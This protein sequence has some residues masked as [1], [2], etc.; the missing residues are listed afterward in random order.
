MTLKHWKNKVHRKRAYF[1]YTLKTKALARDSAFVLIALTGIATEDAVAA[2]LVLE[3]LNARDTLMTNQGL[4]SKGTERSGHSS[5]PRLGE[6]Q[7]SGHTGD[8]PGAVKQGNWTL[9]TR[10][11]QSGAVKQGKLNSQD[12]LATGRGL[13]NKGNSTRRTHWWQVGGCEARETQ[14]AGHIGDKSGVVKQIKLNTQDTLGTSRGLWS[15]GNSMLG[16][17]WWQVRGCEAR[18][19]QRSGHVGD[20]W[21][22]WS[23]GSDGVEAREVTA[24]KQGKLNTQ[25][26][27]AKVES[28]RAQCFSY[29][30]QSLPYFLPFVETFL[31]L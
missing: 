24:L 11:W 2:N 6:T 9:G 4:W 30:D 29:M 19:T 27:Q 3:K 17:R 26:T 20:K 22:R 16:T 14:H 7:R 13:W 23:K 10:W 28:L 25:D 31:L 18:E 12:T 5:E 8:K 21:R 15:K 1:L